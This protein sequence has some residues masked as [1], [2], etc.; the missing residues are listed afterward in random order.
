MMSR[1]K[2]DAVSQW[3]LHLVVIFK[4]DATLNNKVLNL[5]ELQYQILFNESDGIYYSSDLLRV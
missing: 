5:Q 3:W 2:T 4:A 1:Y